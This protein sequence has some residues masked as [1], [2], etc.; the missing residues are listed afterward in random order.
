[1]T[2]LSPGP[3]PQIRTVIVIEWPD[4]TAPGIT[5]SL[6]DPEKYAISARSRVP[7]GEA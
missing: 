3:G 4:R 6:K 1:V 7:E 2:E 5:G